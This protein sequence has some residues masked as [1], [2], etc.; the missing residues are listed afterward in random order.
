MDMIQRDTTYIERSLKAAC[1]TSQFSAQFYPTVIDGLSIDDDVIR[2]IL[3]I[4]TI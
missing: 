2:D 4:R 1:R 3:Y